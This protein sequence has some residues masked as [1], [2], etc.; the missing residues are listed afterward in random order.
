MKKFAKLDRG[1]LETV[2]RGFVTMPAGADPSMGAGPVAG[3]GMLT[4]AQAAPMGGTPQMD[5]AM[6]GGDPAAM[7]GMPPDA[8]AGMP[9]ADA[10]AGMP[11]ADPAAAGGMPPDAGA[12]AP[13]PDA[14]AGM[15]PPSG[16][17]VMSVQDLITLIQAVQ[18]GGAKVPKAK[19]AG[20]A[21][22]GGGGGGSD[23]K[24][25]QIISLL[26]GNMMSGAGTP[27]AG[28]APQQGQ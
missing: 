20:D 5:P 24:L 26:G 15:P 14:G 10:G 2:K 16:Q 19:P 7:G 4:Q 27:S 23:A 12:G 17:I 3:G 6:M 13:P 21:A 11:P 9:P 22:A 25:D 1:L 28:G 18:T 8:G